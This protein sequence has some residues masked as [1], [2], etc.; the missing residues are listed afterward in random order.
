MPVLP[1]LN[2]APLFLLHEAGVAA[3]AV[4]DPISDTRGSA[5]YKRD[6]AGVF[7]QRALDQAWQ[8]A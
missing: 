2:F 6:M 5:A 1:Q 4:T 3:K 7:V 8:N